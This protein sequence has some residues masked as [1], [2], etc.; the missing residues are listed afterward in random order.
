MAIERP[1]WVKDKK[2]ADDFEVIEAQKYDNYKDFEMDKSSYC[3]IKVLWETSQISVAICNQEHVILKEFRGIR[4]QDICKA[5]FDYEEKNKVT[6]FK[7]KAHIA[8]LGKEIKKAEIALA[9][10]YEYVQE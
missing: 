3:L 2:T 6:F 8:Y 10:G 5:I 9:T 7:T 1:S 4:V